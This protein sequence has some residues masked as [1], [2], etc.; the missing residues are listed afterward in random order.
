MGNGTGVACLPPF[1]VRNFWWHGA[2]ETLLLI[3]FK[4]ALVL[5]GRTNNL[6]HAGRD[7]VNSS[8]LASW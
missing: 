3:F 1:Y 8:L 2:G 5:A 4:M 7:T 6:V